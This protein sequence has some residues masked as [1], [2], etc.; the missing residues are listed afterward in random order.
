MIDKMMD[1]KMIEAI[2]EYLNGQD[3]TLI[4]HPRVEP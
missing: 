1:N 3:P 4:P 2:T